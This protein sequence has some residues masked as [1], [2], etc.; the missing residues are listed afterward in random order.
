M[1][2][3]P[4]ELN[5]DLNKLF[6]LNRPKQTG[7]D[8]RALEKAVTLVNTERA[9]LSLHPLQGVPTLFQVAQAHSQDM[10]KRGF[11]GDA[12][13]EGEA[14]TIRARLAGYTGRCEA[15]VA[16]GAEQPEGVIRE[17]LANPAYEKH[18]L[19]EAYQHIGVGC[20]DGLWTFLLG[21]PP[22]LVLSDVKE[23]RLAV[24][25][26]VNDERRRASVTL[27]ELSEALCAAAQEHAADMA[28][29]DYFGTTSPSGDTIPARVA[30]A[31]FKGRSVACL[32]KGP[33]SPEEAVAAVLQTSR[34]N[35]LHPEIR[36]LGV[37]VTAG[38]WV[39]VLGTI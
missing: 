15:L 30:K 23:L 31:G 13:P 3:K 1:E 18:L 21:A 20:S 26:R 10:E 19:S 7:P 38:R 6:G 12:T 28:Q 4:V 2:R 24:L 29:R 11:L 37:A 34:G 9:K 33:G 25:G 14:V 35:V 17:W 16:A 22:S 32:A 8:V 5:L 39:L 36:F 27:L